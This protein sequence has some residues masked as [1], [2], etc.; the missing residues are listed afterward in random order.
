[1]GAQQNDP[2][3]SRELPNHRRAKALPQKFEATINL[4]SEKI[5]ESFRAL[6]AKT[7]TKCSARAFPPFTMFSGGFRKQ[8]GVAILD[9]IPR[10]GFG[11]PD[12]PVIGIHF[13]ADGLVKIS[14]AELTESIFFVHRL[15]SKVQGF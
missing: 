13:Q 15:Y 3:G 2:K 14:K 9:I 7:T 8:F 12:P 11:F 1:M 5:R 10:D 6:R 4:G